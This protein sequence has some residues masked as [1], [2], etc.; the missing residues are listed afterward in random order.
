MFFLRYI[1][2]YLKRYYRIEHGT[3]FIDALR[4]VNRPSEV[5]VPNELIPAGVL[6]QL[7][8]LFNLHALSINNDWVWPYWIEQQ[9]NPKSASFIPRAMNLTYV[10]LTHRNWTAVGVLGQKR[11]A[12]VDPRGLVTPWMQGWSLDTWIRVGGKYCF[13]SRIPSDKLCQGLRR[14]L[15]FVMTSFKANELVVRLETWA[16]RQDDW[17]YVAHEAEISNPTDKPLSCE[18]VF[19]IRPYNPEGLSLVRNLAYNTRGFWNIE[20]QVAAFFPERPD[21]SVASEHAIGDVSAHL[22]DHRDDTSVMCHVGLAT[23]AS[24]YRLT[25]PPGES[26]LRYALMPMDPLNPRFFAF[27]RFTPETIA[28]AK[29][30]VLGD[31]DRKMSEGTTIELPDPRYQASFEANKAFLVLLNDGHEITAGPLTYHRHWFRDAA[32]LVNALDKSGYNDDVAKLLRYFPLKQWKNGYFCSQ[33]GEWDSNGEAIWAIVDHYRLTGDKALLEELYPALKRA[34]L[35]IEKKRHDVSF[36][37]LKPKGLLPAGFSAEH[38]GP[39]DYYYWDNF[40]SLCGVRDA[41]YAAEE[42][43]RYDDVQMFES[44]Y[45]AYSRDLEEAMNRDIEHSGKHVLPAAPGRRPDSGM[46]GNIAAAYPLQLFSLEHTQWLRNT[47]D[48]IR[49]HLFHE[50]GFYQQMIHSGVNSYLTMQ[51][52]HCMVFMGDI[53]AYK[54]MEY[55]LKL[56]TT[57]YC[58]PEAIHPRTLGGCMGDGHHGWAAA[59]WLLLMRNLV[60]HEREDV[61]EL[62]RLLPA[63]WCKPG[64][65]V[66]ILNAPTHFGVVSVAVEFLASGEVLTI[67][68]LWRT[69]PREIH[70]YLPA[71]ARRVVEP[72]EGARLHD[73][74]AILDPSVSRVRLEVALEHAHSVAEGTVPGLDELP[75]A[76]V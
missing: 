73:G 17:D 35:W 10:N 63:E 75:Q 70:W 52:A 7:R 14:N 55:M 37:R 58:W 27:Q 19:A 46:I 54:L 68:A 65:R 71:E 33:K 49:D 13:P 59:E 34:V 42:L 57:T 45:R 61:L 48:F 26:V 66:A 30:K 56:A 38:L 29:E 28:A 32:Y 4:R 21:K 24:V 43:G 15:P 25:I 18:L 51:M 8:G 3:E 64:E 60:V 11:E 22:L 53:G 6:M 44:I 40:W 76:S 2:N 1:V 31:W 9:S 74:I 36:S 69:A 47:V 23:G 16:F 41:L 67:H 12:V 20:G 50:E 39:N 62:T 5:T 72:A